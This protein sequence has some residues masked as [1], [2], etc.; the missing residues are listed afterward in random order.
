MED[1][2]SV[3]EKENADIDE[4]MADPAIGTDLPKLEDLQKKKDANDEELS[5]LYDQWEK[6][7]S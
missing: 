3:L 5:G 6:L 1:R 2:I 7:Q 4:R